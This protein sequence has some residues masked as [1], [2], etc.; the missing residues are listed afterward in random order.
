[1]I[2]GPGH[3]PMHKIKA[4]MDKQLKVC[5]EA[6]FYTLG[7]LVDRRGPRLRPHHLGD[8]RGDDRLVRHRHA[9]LRDAQ[10][11]SGPARPRGRQAGGDRLQDRR[12]RRRPRQ[13]PSGPRAGTMRSRAPASSSAGRTSSTWASIRK[14]RANTTTRPC[15]GGAQDR[16]LLLHVRPEVLLD[17]DQPGNPRT[18]RRR[19]TWRR[20]WPRWRRSSREGGGDLC[21]VRRRCGR[22]TRRCRYHVAMG[23]H[24]IG[25]GFHI[26]NQRRRQMQA[27]NGEHAHRG[28]ILHDLVRSN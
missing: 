12:P 23:V 19:T 17:E 22:A 20:A 24:P 28:A 18:P 1:M 13:G 5:G 2:E 26:S 14:P 21:G 7:P 8:R 9:L 4:N 25:L 27:S 15:Q 11:A 3:V 10:G 16:P 6:P